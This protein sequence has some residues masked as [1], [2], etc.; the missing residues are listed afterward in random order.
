MLSVLT[1]A[2]VFLSD[3]KLLNGTVIDVDSIRQLSSPSFNDFVDSLENGLETLRQANKVKFFG[4]L[5]EEAI[6][7]M[8]PVYE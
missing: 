1:N 6:V 4:C 3:G 2:Q 7:G 5:T 8:G